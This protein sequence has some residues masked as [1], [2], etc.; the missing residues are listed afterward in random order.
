M[1]LLLENIVNISH[2]A[3]ERRA[4]YL[5]WWNSDCKYFHKFR[6][7]GVISREMIG[8]LFK[9]LIIIFFTR[10]QYRCDK[11]ADRIRSLGD[12]FWWVKGHPGGLC[13]NQITPHF[14]SFPPIENLHGLVIM[15]NWKGPLYQILDFSGEWLVIYKPSSSASDR[16]LDL[17][18]SLIGNGNWGL[19][20]PRNRWLSLRLLPLVPLSLLILLL[21]TQ[22]GVN[23]S[24]ESLLA[25]RRMLRS[26]F[27]FYE[28]PINP[29]PTLFL[30]QVSKLSP[31]SPVFGFILL[32]ILLLSHIFRIGSR[33]QYYSK[34]GLR[35]LIC[36]A[37]LVLVHLIWRSIIHRGLLVLILS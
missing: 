30:T 6:K 7:G 16:L 17:G 21:S 1:V 18:C 27:I 13:L 2:S 23:W 4:Q 14:E 29:I 11:P 24:E 22:H 19:R 8:V 3:V 36:I 10:I 33:W 25:T 15:M 12:I 34:G 20:L 26:T 32:I 9:H 5:A 35:G 37:G 28:R 31:Y